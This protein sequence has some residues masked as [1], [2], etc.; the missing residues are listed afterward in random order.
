MKH[1]DPLLKVSII[2]RG[3]STLGFAQ[4][5]PKDQY[6]YTK[7]QLLDRICM[8]LGGRIAEEIFFGKITTG[9]SD[10]LRRVTEMAYSQILTYGMN[11]KV[12][13]ISFPRFGNLNEIGKP[14]SEK[15]AILID[16]EVKS[17]VDYAYQR[18]KNLL[19]E[20]R[21]M[22]ESLALQLIKDE[23][24]SKEQI[25]KMIGPREEKKF[26]PPV[27]PFDLSTKQN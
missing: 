26:V 5:N 18:T 6:L 21:E 4:Y 22:V 10:D 11:D 13:P 7:E 9:A 3:E 8:A 19:L 17:L 24:I 2:P 20:K 23:V 15:T 27:L 25:E 1:V 14:Y 12:G 16:N